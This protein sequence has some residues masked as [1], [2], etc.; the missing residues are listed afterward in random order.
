MLD[1]PARVG[2]RCR[3]SVGVRGSGAG[4]PSALWP[5]FMRPADCAA[6]RLPQSGSDSRMGRLGRQCG[7]EPV[8]GGPLP[9][10][11]GA[12]W[13]A[14]CDQRLA[15]RGRFRARWCAGAG[16]RCR[17]GKSRLVAEAVTQAR[18]AG[19]RVAVGRASAS[20]AVPYRVL[21]EDHRPG[22]SHR[23]RVTSRHGRCRPGPAPAAPVASGSKRK[24]G[25][26]GRAAAILL[27][28]A[29]SCRGPGCGG[30][31]TARCWSTARGLGGEVAVAGDKEGHQEVE[32]DLDPGWPSRVAGGD[33][34]SFVDR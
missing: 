15:R 30:V 10:G 20:A 22:T 19:M 18:V 16:R 7:R 8:R 31:P 14:G 28:C 5:G 12:E 26:T 11:G 23:G 1:P 25:S 34:R 17:A 3:S 29:L 32:A 13:R 9:V 4:V 6:R 21:S 33:P 27:L 24:R 2:S